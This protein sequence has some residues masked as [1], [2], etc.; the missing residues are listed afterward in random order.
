LP[1]QVGNVWGDVA[2]R[3]GDCVADRR[4]ASR[5]RSVDEGDKNS[6]RFV[7]SDLGLIF[8]FCDMAWEFAVRMFKRDWCLDIAGFPTSVAR[9]ANNAVRVDSGGWW[10]RLVYFACVEYTRAGMDFS[11][12]GAETIVGPE[13][14]SRR[15]NG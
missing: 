13:R 4:A 14:L 8:V 10:N 6:C 5:W 11:K 3:P 7:F 2:V 1:G 15:S 9:V 12:L